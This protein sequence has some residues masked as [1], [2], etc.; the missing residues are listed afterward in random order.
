MVILNK[1]KENIMNDINVLYNK[2]DY[3]L[4]VPETFDVYKKW[5]DNTKWRDSWFLNNKDYVICILTYK[6]NDIIHKYLYLEEFYEFFIDENNNIVKKSDNPELNKIID[7][8]FNIKKYDFNNFNELKNAIDNG[9]IGVLNKRNSLKINYK[10]IKD[11]ALSVNPLLIKYIPWY[12][13][14]DKQRIEAVRK[15]GLAI[16]YIP[17]QHIT[18]EIAILALES[19]IDAMFFIPLE[20]L[21]PEIIEDFILKNHYNIRRI[22]YVKVITKELI[23]KLI[24]KFP[25]AMCNVVEFQDYHLCYNAVKKNGKLLK[26]TPNKYRNKKMCK[27]AFKSNSDAYPFIGDN[28]KTKKMTFKA[29]NDN[30]ENIK[31]A[32]KS[33]I[34]KN[35]IIRAVCRKPNLYSNF[36]EFIDIDMLKGFILN[37]DLPLDM[38]PVSEITEEF[39][40]LA[41]EANPF[42]IYYVELFFTKEKCKELCESTF[43]KYNFIINYIDEDYLNNDM[44]EYK[45]KKER[46]MS[47]VDERVEKIKNRFDKI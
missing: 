9:D 30:P 21:T 7:T 16:K 22:P 14:N 23:H 39:F 24:N 11:Y 2:N 29:V 34:N 36:K 12:L 28:Y 17:K 18:R 6:E 3:C 10:E 35:M 26:D 15:N 32:P 46:L 5:V 44:K 43:L 47:G 41:I 37:N 13:I 8:F 33:H 19:Y 38:L 27:A 31:Y 1:K 4:F 40:N 20:V 25:E 45:R 42:N